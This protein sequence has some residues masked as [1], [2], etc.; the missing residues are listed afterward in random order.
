M[1]P[2]TYVPKIDI[3]SYRPRKARRA[4]FRMVLKIVLT[5]SNAPTNRPYKMLTR[6][7]IFRRGLGLELASCQ[8]LGLK[9]GLTVRDKL[10]IY[11][12]VL[13]GFKAAEQHEL[14][15]TTAKT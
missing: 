8:G 13:A 3:T 6:S 1:G 10:V 2:P 7:V 11:F 14:G 12:L 15:L 4:D 5:S 9:L